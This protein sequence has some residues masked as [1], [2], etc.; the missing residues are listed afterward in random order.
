MTFVYLHKDGVIQKLGW[1]NKKRKQQM[2]DFENIKEMRVNSSTYLV[3]AIKGREVEQVKS[4]TYLG[5]IVTIDSGA[6]EDVHSHI[7]KADG[8]FIQLYPVWMNKNILIGTKIQFFNAN[9]NSV[10]LYECE[11]W[12]ITE[13]IDNSL[14]VD[15][16]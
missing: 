2:W 7:R 8:G 1:R 6:L 4:F 15:L 3:L 14:Q 9:V 13:W 5:S 11:M 16:N 12:K 10:L